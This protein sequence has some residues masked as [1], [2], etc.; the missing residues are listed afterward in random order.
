MF[1]RAQVI[2]VNSTGKEAA[3]IFVDLGN[4]RRVKC[5]ELRIPWAYGDQ[6][7]MKKILSS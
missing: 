1:R 3:V 5:G 6:V 7:C 4:I 2:E